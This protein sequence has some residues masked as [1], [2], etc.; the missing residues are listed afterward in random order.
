MDHKIC[1]LHLP[2]DVAICF[3]SAKVIA[4]IHELVMMHFLKMVSSYIHSN[5]V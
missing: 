2:G 3:K 1:I 4:V 5:S